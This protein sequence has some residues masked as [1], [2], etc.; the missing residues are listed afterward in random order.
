[1]P[2]WCFSL[3][4][5]T[6]Y[7]STAFHTTLHYKQRQAQPSPP[8]PLLL[9][10]IIMHNNQRVNVFHCVL[11][12]II[13]FVT[14]IYEAEKP[15]KWSELRCA[16]NQSANGQN[17]CVTSACNLH[18]NFLVFSRSCHGDTRWAFVTF[19]GTIKR[20]RGGGGIVLI[21]TRRQGLFINSKLCK[22][23]S[24]WLCNI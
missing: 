24:A 12:S 20:R 19:N 3:L 22:R 5:P 14:Q 9:G 21:S 10:T 23:M 11:I 13:S 18:V 6:E 7:T 17:K 1:M 8:L 2:H 4:I 15:S 16:G